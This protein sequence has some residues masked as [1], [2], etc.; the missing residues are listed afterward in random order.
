MGGNISKNAADDISLKLRPLH[1]LN[2]DMIGM[3]SIIEFLANEE[4]LIGLNPFQRFHQIL[5]VQA[6]QLLNDEF[7]LLQVLLLMRSGY[8]F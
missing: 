5:H 1:F 4:G 3:F 8:A 7:E 2:E 6:D